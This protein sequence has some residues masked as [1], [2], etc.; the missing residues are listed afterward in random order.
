MPL[1]LDAAYSTVQYIYTVYFYSRTRQDF[2][3][4]LSR[5]LI[6]HPLLCSV[7]VLIA[8]VIDSENL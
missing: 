1:M 3:L 4:R 7:L 6:I 8:I 2:G 5:D